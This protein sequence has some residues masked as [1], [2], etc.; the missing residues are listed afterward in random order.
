MSALSHGL[1]GLDR[2]GYPMGFQAAPERPGRVLDALIVMEHEAEVGRGILPVD[3]L[4]ERVHR[5]LLGD[6]LGHRPADDLA[7]P[8]VDDGRQVQ[9]ALGCVDVGDVAH[10]EVVA[11]IRLENAVDEVDAR[12]AHLDRLR[13]AVLPRSALSLQPQRSHDVQ[14][15]LLAHDDAV[16]PELTVDAT[17][18]VAV[19]AEFELLHDESLQCLAL[20]L[21]VRFPS[22]DVVVVF[23][24]RDL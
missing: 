14:H 7:V 12:I 23:G 24:L 18:A 8:C 2:L 6:A 19:L 11:C 13:P 16:L 21:S 1:P 10:P 4:L 9:P 20:Y 15:A 17:I 22:L 5:E 3:R